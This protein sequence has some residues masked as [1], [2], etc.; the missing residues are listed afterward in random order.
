MPVQSWGHAAYWTTTSTEVTPVVPSSGH[1]GYPLWQSGVIVGSGFG[2]LAGYWDL[3]RERV[4]VIWAIAKRM[5]FLSP[6]ECAVVWRT[7]DLVSSP[8]F[9]IAVRA[10]KQTATKI[11]FNRSE[12]WGDL[13]GELKRDPG[14]AENTYRHLHTVNT[15]RLNYV[16]STLSNPQAHLLVELAYHGYALRKVR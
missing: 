7:L 10:V 3:W 15:L 2:A 6:V 8:A 14:N 4:K 5:W 13:K 9:P 16:G 12:A 11:G 1:P